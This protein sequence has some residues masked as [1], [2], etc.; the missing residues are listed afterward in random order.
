[1]PRDAACSMTARVTIRPATPGDSE[2][3]LALQQRAYQ[4]EARLYD[5]WTLPPLTQSLA[6]MRED[7]ATMTVLAAVAGDTIIG[8]VRGLLG[9]GICHIGRL[10]VDP[11]YQGQGI[12]TA[13]LDAI[14]NHFP[15]AKVF[16]LFTGSRS[17]GNLHLYHRLGYREFRRQTVAPHLELVFL[18]KAGSC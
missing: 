3:L 8:S 13:L 10:L 9:E 5:D 4:S 12:G 17:S 15:E 14:E 7:I 6:S 16:Q 11:E 2:T 1:M 18:R